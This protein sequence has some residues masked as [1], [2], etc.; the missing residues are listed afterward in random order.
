MMSRKEE[1]GL[2]RVSKEAL[3]LVRFKAFSKKI[4]NKEYVE[5]LI[6]EDTKDIQ[7]IKMLNQILN[8]IN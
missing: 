8:K 5:K 7:D 4:T 2:I 6:L 1:T 3:D